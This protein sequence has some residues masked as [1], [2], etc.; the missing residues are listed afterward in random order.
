M[1]SNERKKLIKASA[2][3]LI[4]KDQEI[5]HLKITSPEVL[6]KNRL[7]GRNMLYL[8]VLT[9][10]LGLYLHD[11]GWQIMFMFFS[12]TLAAIGLWRLENQRKKP[13]KRLF[14]S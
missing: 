11:S 9:A 3:A 12:L 5:S 7:F 1:D 14:R 2:E 4:Q 10:V 6:E 8:S 13:F